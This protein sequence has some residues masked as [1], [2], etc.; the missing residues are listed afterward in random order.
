VAEP[1]IVVAAVETES[2]TVVVAEE[3]VEETLLTAWTIVS[4][5]VLRLTVALA[6]VLMLELVVATDVLLV[7]EVYTLE[8]TLELL[9]RVA[10]V[11]FDDSA[12]VLTEV[13]VDEALDWTV[14]LLDWVV[15]VALD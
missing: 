13:V 15:V 8:P 11:V 3:A 5:F 9:T 12:A 6:W 10:C 14:V 1:I 4:T 7:A 2:T